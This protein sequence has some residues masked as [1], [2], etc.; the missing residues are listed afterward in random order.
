MDFNNT[1]KPNKKLKN[2]HWFFFWKEIFV[3]CYGLCVLS[4]DILILIYNT[5]EKMH[6]MDCILNRFCKQI[7]VC[8]SFICQIFH[9]LNCH[10]TLTKHGDR[11]NLT[12]CFIYSSFD[13]KIT[14]LHLPHLWNTR[15]VENIFKQSINSRQFSKSYSLSGFPKYANMNTEKG[16]FKL[17]SIS[18]FKPFNL[19]HFRLQSFASG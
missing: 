2:A 15:G 3:E 6:H 8:V 19:S 1:T 10:R 12:N 16:K 14:K 4:F 17:N 13:I 9:S 11:H 18:I 5:M 7:N